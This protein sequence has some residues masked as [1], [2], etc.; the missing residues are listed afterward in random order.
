[1]QRAR[2]IPS[3]ESQVFPARRGD[4]NPW[5][6]RVCMGT[7]GAARAQEEPS[8]RRDTC[9][10]SP[11]RSDLP[12]GPLHLLTLAINIPTV[13]LKNHPT[14]QYFPIPSL[15]RGSS[16]RR[17]CCARV[18]LKRKGFHGTHRGIGTAFYFTL[19]MA[20]VPG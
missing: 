20:R 9:R 10:P 4:S 13:K 17:R 8:R 14:S 11:H 15:S 19:L 18:C 12:T 7:G 1:M 16:H 5:T 2:L 6:Q 3:G